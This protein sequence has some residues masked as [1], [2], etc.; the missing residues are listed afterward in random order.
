MEKT[1]GQETQCS[2]ENYADETPNRV[3]RRRKAIVPKICFEA[4]ED[5]GLETERALQM[6]SLRR[7]A[8]P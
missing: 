3:K 5:E 1:E 6:W 8:Q 4:S 7:K 2:K